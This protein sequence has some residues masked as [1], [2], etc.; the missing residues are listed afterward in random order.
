QLPRDAV[1]LVGHQAP[2]RH[3][4]AV[5]AR[6]RE[7]RIARGV[8]PLADRSQIGDCQDADTHT[9]LYRPLPPITHLW[10]FAPQMAPAPPPP[11][12]ACGARRSSIGCPAWPL[13][14]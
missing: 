9:A 2:H 12:P 4:V 3:F 7:N 6:P 1:G 11:A 10:S 5:R 13:P 8:G 14:P